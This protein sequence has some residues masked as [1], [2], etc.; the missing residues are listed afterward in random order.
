MIVRFIKHPHI[1][2]A[3]TKW[4]LNEKTWRGE[5]S[6]LQ[7][8]LSLNSLIEEESSIVATKVAFEISKYPIDGALALEK[9]HNEDMED[10]RYSSI[11]GEVYI[12]DL[13]LLYF[14]E[15]YPNKIY[16]KYV[17]ET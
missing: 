12:C 13:L 4:H 15:G 2:S 7:L 1:D 3:S 10:G 5:T 11:I 6:E 8:P 16:Y 17:H 9:I 14:P